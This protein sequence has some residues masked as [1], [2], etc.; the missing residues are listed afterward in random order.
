MA[1]GCEELYV[2]RRQRVGGRD[3]EGEEPATTAVGRGWW[4]RQDG[5]PVGE[6]GVGEGVEIG[7]G[8]GGKI[9]GEGFQFLA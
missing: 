2:W 7:K 4:A 3:G 9:G 6:I 5:A 8:G 1:A